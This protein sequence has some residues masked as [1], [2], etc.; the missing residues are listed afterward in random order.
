MSIDKDDLKNADKLWEVR[1]KIADGNEKIFEFDLIVIVIGLFSTSYMPIIRGQN[2]FLDSIIHICDIKSSKQLENKHVVVLDEGKSAFDL[3]ITA[4]TYA[5]IC[6]I[7]FRRA[8]WLILNHL[9][10]GRLSSRY[11]FSPVSS[12]VLDPYPYGPH[13]ALFRLTIK[14]FAKEFI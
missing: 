10:D 5:K 6:H 11:L 13:D 12:T 9:M 8:H 1:V 14:F 4:G 3:T 2:K 7:L